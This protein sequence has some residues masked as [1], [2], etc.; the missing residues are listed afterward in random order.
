M[1]TLVA[2]G[3]ISAVEPEVVMF[4]PSPWLRMIALAWVSGCQVATSPCDDADGD[5]VCDAVDACTGDEA[6]G[7]TDGDGV[8]DDLDACSGDDALGD[9]D[10]DGVCDDL[11]ACDGPGAAVD[12]DHDGLCGT[13]DA[14]IGHDGT[15]DS[16]GDGICDDVDPCDDA[17]V[18]PGT[19]C[20]PPTPVPANACVGAPVLHQGRH[21][22]FVTCPDGAINR[23]FPTAGWAAA[24]EPS[25]EVHA[26][27]FLP[28]CE[29]TPC[30]AAPA[31]VCGSLYDGQ[32]PYGVCTYGCD[33]D[34]DCTP[35]QACLPPSVGSDRGFVAMDPL[36]GR[37][38]CVDAGCRE[39]ADCATSECGYDHENAP[40]DQLYLPR[41][42]CRDPAADDCRTDATCATWDDGWGGS[43]TFC[44]ADGTFQCQYYDPSCGRPLHDETGRVQTAPTV[45]RADWHAPMTPAAA[46]EELSAH[47]AH[48]GALEHAS[49]ASF[50]RH[51]LELLWL[52]A[53]AALVGE[54]L[55]AQADEIEHARLAYGLASR[56]AT[57]PVGPGPLTAA[58]SPRQAVT[59]I[60]DGLVTEGCL[61]ETLAAVEAGVAARRCADPEVRAVLRRIAADEARHAALAWKT[62]GWMVQQY[63]ELRGRLAV[64]VAAARAPVG[65]VAS[66]PRSADGLVSTSEHVA[67]RQQVLREVV[68]VHVTSLAAAA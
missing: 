14:C 2:V 51:L 29:S 23:L 16:D 27:S 42:M 66:H 64:L 9:S 63:P 3:C 44:E 65:P 18:P 41:M 68:S 37:G 5:G 47:W 54:V 15:G 43:A 24:A 28:V 33:A 35:G 46:D 60:F 1:C 20:N 36:L 34:A 61:E 22:G 55:A 56:F 58:A 52:G 50:A 31:G 8:C 10:G 57:T 17:V 4:T 39:S 30:D 11:D 67:L 59:E 26:Y 21:T 7:D 38:I 12:D 62:A 32:T 49:V 6:V 13:A 40:C 19:A 25:T 53:P 45:E 48:I